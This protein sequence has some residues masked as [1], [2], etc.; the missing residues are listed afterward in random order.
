M[1]QH[2]VT[3]VKIVFC[4]VAVLLRAMVLDGPAGRVGRAT[5]ID[6]QM[7]EIFLSLRLAR[8]LQARTVAFNV[9]THKYLSPIPIL[10]LLLA[11]FYEVPIVHLIQL[12]CGF[13]RGSTHRNNGLRSAGNW[14]SIG[15]SRI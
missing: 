1:C 6:A 5:A 12:N 8:F 11:R 15:R 9:L 7:V 3:I 10:H 4:W 2:R 14:C 13:C